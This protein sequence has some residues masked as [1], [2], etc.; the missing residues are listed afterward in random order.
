[1][2]DLFGFLAQHWSMGVIGLFTTMAAWREKNPQTVRATREAI[3][4]A[5]RAA[6]LQQK[7]M[8]ADLHMDEG[9]LTRA[10]QAGGNLAA[11]VVLGTRYP[12]FG[13]ALV[14]RLGE[15]LRGA[16]ESPVARYERLIAELDALPRKEPAKCE[17]C[18]GDRS[19]SVSSV[20]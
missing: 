12:V 17:A 2:D 7:V 10:L 14:N 9:Q 15:L 3:D 18:D 20:A 19:S 4:A 5:R 8:A 6:N 1:M 11:L 16:H 13:A